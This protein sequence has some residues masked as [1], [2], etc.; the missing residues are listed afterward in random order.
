MTTLGPMLLFRL[1]TTWKTVD[2]QFYLTRLISQTLTLLT[3]HLF[4]SMQNALTGIRF[5]LEQRIKNWL[6]SFLATM[7]AQFFWDI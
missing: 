6:D 3:Y 2:E 5:T 1:R 4:R 7:P